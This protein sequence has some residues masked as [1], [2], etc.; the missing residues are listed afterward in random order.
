[1]S[2]LPPP[3]EWGE[4]IVIKREGQHL[5]E[6]KSVLPGILVV[7]VLAG[8][9]TL[10]FTFLTAEAPPAAAPTKTPGIVSAPVITEKM[11]QAKN[12][13][14]AFYIGRG[15]VEGANQVMRDLIVVN[16]CQVINAYFVPVSSRKVATEKATEYETLA[17]NSYPTALVAVSV[18][19]TSGEM[20]ERGEFVAVG[21]V[22]QCP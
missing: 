2:D 15:E 22:V 10:V 9:A 19:S 8:L 1:M 11:L 4:P 7:L 5:K 14:A 16:G 18:A 6:P 13:R 20:A 17:R 12:D 21:I 3:P